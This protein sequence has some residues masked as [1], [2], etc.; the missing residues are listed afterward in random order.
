MHFSYVQSCLDLFQRTIVPK[1]I[2]NIYINI[3][4]LNIS[5]GRNLRKLLRYTF[6]DFEARL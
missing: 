3:A 6:L 1:R 5:K 2:K 4:S